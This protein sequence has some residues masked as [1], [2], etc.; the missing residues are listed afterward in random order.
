MNTVYWLMFVPAITVDTT[1][2]NSANTANTSYAK[3][4]ILSDSDGHTVT[5]SM[6]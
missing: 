4:D 6:N 3:F 5:Q 2:A 1:Q